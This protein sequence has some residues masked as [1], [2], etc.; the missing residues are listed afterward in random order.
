MEAMMIESNTLDGLNC[1]K[2]YMLWFN[3]SIFI[4]LSKFL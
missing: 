1:S 4:F 2:L 3:F